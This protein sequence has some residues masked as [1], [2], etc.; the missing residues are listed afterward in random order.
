VLARYELA[1][2]DAAA[3]AVAVHGLAARAVLGG[4]MLVRACDARAA[5][6]STDAER[7]AA[8]A[9]TL[10]AA[11][12]RP[13]V[14]AVWQALQRRGIREQELVE[15]PGS[16]ALL[17]LLGGNA[18]Q[19]G[20]TRRIVGAIHAIAG[21][22]QGAV[23]DLAAAVVVAHGQ[24][25]RISAG[26]EL[27]QGVL[28]ALRSLAAADPQSA[29]SPAVE[30]CV[31]LLAVITDAAHLPD[32]EDAALGDSMVAR[33][34]RLDRSIAHCRA[35]ERE[36]RYERYANAVESAE[37]ALNAAARERL[38][39]ALGTRGL[40]RRLLRAVASVIARDSV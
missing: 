9:V 18:Q 25:V 37:V 12:E 29:P 2:P 1:R 40:Q 17:P 23:Q 35:V 30:V 34:Q 14:E 4:A 5:G 13:G 3:Q 27:S 36:D 32:L 7:F 22:N 28:A 31:E 33:L 19:A 10:L 26:G 6:R 39:E 15:L 20:L 24:R 11:A 8:S 21:G 16:D 38:R